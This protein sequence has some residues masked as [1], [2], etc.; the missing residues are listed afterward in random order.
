LPYRPWMIAYFV[1]RPVTAQ[2]VLT[3]PNDGVALALL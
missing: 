2:I 1:N 3:G